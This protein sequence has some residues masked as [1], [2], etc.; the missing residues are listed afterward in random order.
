[1]TISI[2]TLNPGE[3]KSLVDL[4]AKNT[5]EHLWLRECSFTG[6][7]CNALA[8]AFP[9]MTSL[10]ELFIWRPSVI[11]DAA[12]GQL[13]SSAC[14]PSLKEFVLWKTTITH[15][16]Q[17][18]L[19]DAIKAMEILQR[20]EL[21]DLSGWS[22]E[23]FRRLFSAIA[24]KAQ[25]KILTLEKMGLGKNSLT[26]DLCQIIVSLPSLEELNLNE[27]ALNA[28]GFVKLLDCLKERPKQLKRLDIRRNTK[29]A[30]KQGFVIWWK[31]AF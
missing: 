16:N 2:S 29:P 7:I 13:L 28:G 11:D 9:Q 20:L 5:I 27:N 4:F 30:D 10:Q 21:I 19:V 26:D 25:L 1:L 15:Q 24:A 3:E 31:R 14:S 6:E 23:S 22:D 18:L 17:L 12:F 8:T